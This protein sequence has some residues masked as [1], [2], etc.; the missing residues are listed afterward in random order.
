MLRGLTDRPNVQSTLILSRKDGS[1]IQA[2]GF[3][4]AEKNTTGRWLQTQQVG[5]EAEGADRKSPGAEASDVVG[6]EQE[7]PKPAELLASSIF[8]FVTYA[9]VLG[10]A[11]GSTSRNATGPGPE[12]NPAGSSYGN[13]PDAF[14]QE[15]NAEDETERGVSED[16]VQLLRLRTKNQEII[17]FPDP[18][19]LCC[20]VQRVGKAG[21]GH[22][23]R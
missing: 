5:Q 10:A 22:D 14:K 23:R 21:T 19:Y 11:L 17:I 16:E 7:E 3:A 9:N 13:G 4:A 1:I 20:V 2:T 15:A 12:G 6:H 8:Q 18:N